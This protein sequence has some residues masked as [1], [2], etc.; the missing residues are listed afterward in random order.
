MG[1]LA[2]K[3]P[4]ITVICRNRRSAEELSRDAAFFCTSKTIINYP[5]WDTLPF[6][7]VSPQTYLSAERLYALRMLQVSR[8][9][10]CITSPE[11][12]CQ[13]V[14]PPE[15]LQQMCFK[16]LVENEYQRD[17]LVGRLNSAAYQR[18]ALVEEVGQYAIRGGVIDIAPAGCRD[19]IRIEFYG[20]R[21]EAIR[22]F[23]FESQRSFKDIYEI[24]IIPVREL[25]LFGGNQ[26]FKSMLPLAS[27]K[28]KQRCGEL[29][30]PLRE[31]QAIIQA[32][33]QDLI[34]PGHE[35]ICATALSPLAS[36]FDYLPSKQLIVID[37]EIKIDQRMDLMLEDVAGRAEQLQQEHIFIP[38]SDDM[39]ITAAQFHDALDQFPCSFFDSIEVYT[40]EQ[41]EQIESINI[42]SISNTELVTRLKTK[43]GT[44]KALQP[45]AQ[46][47]KLWRSSGWQVAFVVGSTQRANRLQK[48]LLDIDI[49]ARISEE[50]GHDWL[51][52]SR[53]S[54]VI[55][56]LGQISKG[57]QLP[58]ANAVFISE[59]ELFAERSYRS[60]ARSN[61]TLKR[62][63]SSLGQLKENDFVVH[64]NYG[65]GIYRGLKHLTVEGVAGDFLQIDY[66]DSKLFL[67]IIN[68]SHIQK[69]AAA[70][71]QQPTIDRLGSNRWLRTKERVKESVLALAGDLIKLYAARSIVPGWRFEPQGA[72]D[73]RF[74]DGFP[75]DETEDQS[76]A[77]EATLADMASSKPTD[78]LICGDVGFG[79]TE[80]ALRA[81]F[82]CTQHARQVAVLAPTTVLVEQHKKTFNDRFLGYPVEIRAISRFYPPAQN[83]K[84]LKDLAEGKID[85]VIG[86]HRLLQKDV[87]F[88]DLGLLIID[89]EH[90]FGVKQKERLKQFR[91]NVDVLTLTA[92][93][94]PRTLHMALLDIKDISTISTPPH[95]RKVIRT[96]ISTY[97]DA[98]IRDAIQRELQR[99]G[100]CFY[101]HN[102]IDSIGLL[103]E[104][105]S[106]LVT[107][108]RFAFAHGQMSENHLERIMQSFLNGE[109]DV[110]V[111]TTIIESGLDIPNANTIIIERADTFGLAQLYQLRGRVGRSTQQAYA[112]LIIPERRKLGNDAQQRLK[113]LQALDDLGLGF[114]LAIRD[115]EIRGAG[116]L[117]G[118]EQ[119][120]NVL[121]VGFEL[122]TKILKEAVMNLKG[123]ELDLEEQI[124]P[125]IKINI[126][127]FIP[128]HY[129]PDIS[130]RLIVYQRLAAIR[131]A[132][133][134]SSLTEEIEDRFG[135]LPV[136]AQQ[137]IEVMQ[138]RTALKGYGVTKA[139][140]SEKRTVLS[141]SPRAPIDSEKILRLIQQSNKLMRFKRNH[142]LSIEHTKEIS[143][144]GPTT[145]LNEIQDILEQLSSKSQ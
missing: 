55:I 9:C 136:E 129:I 51:T 115:L 92:T 90:R 97:S 77:I 69:F 108:A 25:I 11:A 85:I 33:E 88:A 44:G 117:L 13:K 104:K 141:F 107:E 49:S 40:S 138:F 125:E 95:D 120:G 31:S 123:S 109:I 60:K 5:A 54:P 94:I 110:L 36:F 121:A 56:L 137:L 111:C 32:F 24:E 119:S 30:I 39:Y 16:L 126:A 50:S 61:K 2:S 64:D 43:V 59:N 42:R 38:N 58:T 139:E 20:N 101:V 105:L 74:A 45:L 47:I 100:Q 19:P 84:S 113:A 3:S 93:P 48:L 124:D 41:L 66:A 28:I 75:Y 68:I 142:V 53:R 12:V 131:S 127:A 89:E 67:P 122:Y 80:V 98:L 21:I 103:T 52:G 134:A 144:T 81:A 57:F 17:E 72:E 15:L 70:E 71:G 79:K 29:E 63:L 143:K 83:R 1:N 37:D 35:L 34:L 106:E 82:K 86:T 102:R 128:E 14:L 4:I 130:E 23:D 91:K 18:V 132:Q 135:P 96:Y 118:K 116:N 114:N 10:I 140:C 78:R 7:P 145:R 76:A 27:D 6:E 99:G 22:Y 112:Y 65:I 26:R 73:D 46:L 133:E 8:P 62:L 87:S